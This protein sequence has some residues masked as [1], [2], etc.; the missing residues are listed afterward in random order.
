M[1]SRQNKAAPRPPGEADNACKL[2]RR[3]VVM[4]VSGCGKSEIGDRLARY[5]GCRHVEGDAYHSPRNVEKMSAGLPLNDD[6]RRDWLLRIRDEIAAAAARPEC[7]VISCS[8]LKRQYRDLLR[9]GDPALQFVHLAGDRDL[10]VQRMRA[11]PNHFMPI[12]LV[13]SQFKDLEPLGSD[14]AGVVLDIRL[15]PD[16]LVR[17][18]VAAYPGIPATKKE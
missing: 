3:F 6:D 11:R 14:E 9:T 16:D 13:D 12:S 2:D 5:L 7:L 1:T 15:A 10:I 8:A 4:G 17:H 18:V